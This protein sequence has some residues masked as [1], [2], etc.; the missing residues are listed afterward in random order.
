VASAVRDDLLVPHAQSGGGL[1]LGL[2]VQSQTGPGVVEIGARLGL[3]IGAD[4]L[5]ALGLAMGHGL[6]LRYCLPVLSSRT[7]QIAVGPAAGL[8]A[9]I[10]YFGDWDDAHA[11]WMG[12]AWLGGAGRAWRSLGAPLAGA[13][14][15]P[16]FSTA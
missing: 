7:W 15:C 3:G 13:S 6:G 9:D 4:R 16:S 10:F 2:A 11:Y 12:A 14:A 1:A 8:D 5:G